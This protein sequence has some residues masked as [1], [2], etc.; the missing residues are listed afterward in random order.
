VF[1]A[2]SILRINVTSQAGDVCAQNAPGSNG[3]P[4]GTIT[5]TDNG[6]ALDGTPV[7]SGHFALN[8]LGYAEDQTIFLLGG[9]HSLAASYSGDNSFTAGTPNT[10]PPDSV[11]ITTAPT[12]IALTESNPIVQTGSGVVFTATINTK[13]FLP[14]SVSLKPAYFPGGTVQFMAGSTPIA[15][16]ITYIPGRDP[17]GN[18]Q[19]LALLGT[20][21]LPVGNST[22]TAQ[23]LGDQDYSASAVSNSEI[24]DVVIPTTTTLST[25]NPTIQH[26]SSV[27]FTAHVA[28]NQAGPA[29][30]G[31]VQFFLNS[32]VGPSIGTAPVTNGQAQLTTSALPG[33]S[34]TVIASYSGDTNYGESANAV[35]ETVNLLGSTT[36]ISSSTS[37]IQQGSTVTL[38][39]Q[40]A[41]VQP[42]GPALTGSV[43]FLSN[44]SPL[45]PLGLT[46]GKAQLSTT[47]LAVGSDQ[48]TVSYSG[49][50][51]Y[52]ASTSSPI[53]ITV[54]AAPDFSI[55]ANP[56]SI[57]IATPGQTGST[58]L[59]LAAINGLTGT[60]SL[61]PQCVS[62]PSESTC[63]VSPASVT[64]S[65][66]TTTA[67]VM[68][69]VSTRAPSSVPA[70]RRF[71]PTNNRPGPIFIIGLLALLALLS[72]LV[73]RRDRRGIQIA[74][75]VVTFA[76]LLT[77][78]ACGG[79]SGGGGGGVHDPGTPVGLDSAASVSFTIGTATHAVPISINVQ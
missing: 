39:A 3:C 5:L 6:T 70:T 79:G 16:Q 36:T 46:L 19:L 40:V 78:A 13:I 32:G 72:L 33:G 12:T 53:T 20:S 15:G 58:S 55:A 42:G 31:T 64:F 37:M 57:T 56:T 48:I 60:F 11:S 21:T 8:S 18:A 77:F 22:V 26:G 52:A 35:T 30:T 43:Q 47:S 67:T 2:L 49:D 62:L 23:Y 51:N 29:I 63:A 9:Q 25:S 75:S 34:L 73:L 76:A 41:A 14:S 28:G 69:T 17:D 44:G 71:Q 7:G 68:L 38:S 10:S 66:T 27:T 54:T 65:S 24:V 45:A 61:V 4:T 59:M 50:S 1:G 74:F